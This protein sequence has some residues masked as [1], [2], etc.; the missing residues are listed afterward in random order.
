MYKGTSKFRAHNSTASN[1]VIF[2]LSQCIDVSPMCGHIHVHACMYMCMNRLE[3]PGTCVYTCTRIG[4]ATHQRI[5]QVE[6][7]DGSP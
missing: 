2:E 7:G 4:T 3:L 1:R 5:G 6:V